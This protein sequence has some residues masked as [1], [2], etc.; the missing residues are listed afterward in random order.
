MFIDIAVGLLLF[1]WLF[2]GYR[3]GLLG[4]VVHLGGVVLGVMFAGN[5]VRMAAEKVEP[6]LD[7]IPADVRPS[8]MHLGAIVIIAIAVWIIGSLTLGRNRSKWFGGGPSPFDRAMGG[9]LAVAVGCVVVC[10]LVAGSEQMPKEIRN[11]EIV[12]QQ[13][14]QSLAVEWSKKTS[15]ADWVMDVPEMQD[16]VAHAQVVFDKVRHSKSKSAGEKVEELADEL[17]K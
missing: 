10:L 17:L 3:R 1:S 12:K 8:A 4:E 16:A 9:A 11:N 15:V 6:H 2:R 7:K 5:L 14:D 13:L